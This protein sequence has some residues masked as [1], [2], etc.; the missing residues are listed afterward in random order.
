MYKYKLL[1]IF[2]KENLF[3]K[4]NILYLIIF[5]SNYNKS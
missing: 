4:E 3:I 5:D 2:E 1:K